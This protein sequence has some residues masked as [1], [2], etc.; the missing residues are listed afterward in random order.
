MAKKNAHNIFIVLIIVTV[1][2]T[3]LASPTATLADTATLENLGKHP[4]IHTITESV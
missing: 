3:T 4:L 1:F 2:G